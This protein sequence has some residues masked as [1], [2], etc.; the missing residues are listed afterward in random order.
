MQWP[1]SHHRAWSRSWSGHPAGAGCCPGD[2]AACRSFPRPRAWGRSRPRIPA[3][4]WTVRCLPAGLS[5]RCGFPAG[6][7][8]GTPPGT[9]GDPGGYFRG[10]P[11][12]QATTGRPLPA[13]CLPRSG[14]VLAW[15]RT[16]PPYA[17]IGRGTQ[18]GPR[19]RGP[20]NGPGNARGHRR[21]PP[22]RSPVPVCRGLSWLAPRHRAQAPREPRHRRF[23]LRRSYGP[24]WHGLWVTVCVYARG[25]VSTGISNLIEVRP[26]V[27]PRLKVVCA[28]RAHCPTSYQGSS[29]LKKTQ[30]FLSRDGKGS[31]EGVWSLSPGV[32]SE[33]LLNISVVLVMVSSL[34]I[35][36]R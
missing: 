24:P 8:Q 20:Q 16:V 21:A 3:G 14:P 11:F 32:L 17:P 25:A 10:P 36:A 28:I 18:N 33:Q 2:P 30:R 4:A 6:A 13:A 35:P 12:D 34:L 9:G 1:L 27:G 15:A 22:P 31:L 26:Y 23:R 19:R 7:L 29:H 5:P